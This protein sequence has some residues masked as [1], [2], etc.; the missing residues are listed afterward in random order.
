MLMSSSKLV[1]Y[2]WLSHNHTWLELTLLPSL[3]DCPFTV[4]SL[5]L[6]RVSEWT[7]FIMI[8]ISHFAD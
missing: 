2:T 8:I 4:Q 7:A 5:D 6:F 3:A 1:Q